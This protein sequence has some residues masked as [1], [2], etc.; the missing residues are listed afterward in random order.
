M[1]GSLF[2]QWNRDWLDIAIG[3]DRAYRGSRSI[4][5][6]FWNLLTIGT[7]WTERSGG[8]F[9]TERSGWTAW[10]IWTGVSIFWL[11]ASVVS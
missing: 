10:T 8:T 1:P 5:F 7:A 3:A 6:R 2:E 9:W 4:T 11:A